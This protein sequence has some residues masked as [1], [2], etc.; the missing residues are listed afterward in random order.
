MF[1]EITFYTSLSNIMRRYSVPV[2]FSHFLVAIFPVFDYG[3]KLR[4]V[5]ERYVR[6]LNFL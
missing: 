4:T 6:M 5:Y 2:L 3:A 1:V